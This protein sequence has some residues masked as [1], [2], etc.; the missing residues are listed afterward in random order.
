MNI[1]KNGYLYIWVSNE[2]KNWDVFFDNLSVQHKQGPVLEENHYYPFGLMMAG[3]SDKAVKTNYAEN[4]YRY[5]KGS[6]LQNKEFSD[7]S[8][9]EMYETNLREL[10]P[11][12]GKW[13]QLDSKPDYSQSLYASMGNNPILKNDPLGDSSIQPHKGTE[14]TVAITLGFSFKAD[15]KIDATPIKGGVEMTTGE[16]DLIGFRKNDFKLG[17]HNFSNGN[18]EYSKKIGGNILGFGGSTGTEG[19]FNRKSGAKKKR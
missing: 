17:G 13:W 7:G 18:Q 3:I 8:G 1:A 16:I 6:E 10:D 5:N 11:Q 2:T 14:T 4:K 15:F 12:L 9:L 19:S